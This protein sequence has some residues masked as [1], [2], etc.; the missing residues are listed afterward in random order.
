MERVRKGGRDQRGGGRCSTC[1]KGKV[2]EE[3]NQSSE[4]FSLPRTGLMFDLEVRGRKDLWEE[5]HASAAR[6]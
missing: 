3:S 4:W 2:G 5:E 1:G 6:K